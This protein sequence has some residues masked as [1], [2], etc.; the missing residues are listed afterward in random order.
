MLVNKSFYCLKS[1]KE[2]QKML[3]RKVKILSYITSFI[4]V[5]V[6]V[7]LMFFEMPGYIYIVFGVALPIFINFFIRAMENENIKKSALLRCGAY[8]T[9]IFNE[10]SVDIHQESKLGVFNDAYFYN[11]FI[12]VYKNKEYYFF[13]VTRAQAFIVEVNGFVSGNDKELDELLIKVMGKRFINKG[14]K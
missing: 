14:H 11:E 7:V 10:E 12:S 9:F 2:F 8:Q 6:G 1:Y 3:Y 5:I 4:L 13:F